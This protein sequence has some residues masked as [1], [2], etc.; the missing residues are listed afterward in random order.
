MDS[1]WS[2]HELFG[3]FEKPKRVASP[4][5]DWDESECRASEFDPASFTDAKVIGGSLG[6][7]CARPQPPARTITAWSVLQWGGA[8]AVLAVAANVLFGFGQR[9]AA[10]RWL[11]VAARAGAFEATLPRASY[12]SVRDTIERRLQRISAVEGWEFTLLQNGAPA[13]RQLPENEGDVFSVTVTARMSTK[14]TWL[15][16]FPVREAPITVQAEIR[17]PGRRAAPPTQLSAK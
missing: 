11:Q 9:V 10:E 16:W 1:S 8:I 4:D 17:R 5:F 3:H 7:R 12:D 15:R 14:S 6:A 13:F 2:S